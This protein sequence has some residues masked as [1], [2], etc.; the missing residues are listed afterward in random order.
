MKLG[1]YVIGRDVVTFVM[2]ALTV[3]A[4]AATH[5]G[6]DVWLIGGSHRWAAGAIV[7]LG[8]AVFLFEALERSIP[9][10]LF[11]ALGVLAVVLAGIAFW[12]AS[13]TPLSILVATIVVVWA[14][15]AVADTV[16]AGGR[17][18]AT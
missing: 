1:R 4:Y 2:T 5:E 13:L 9:E 3:L 8:A 17:P 12:T 10:G 6:W 16:R 7:F 18:I 15:T 11:G 14:A